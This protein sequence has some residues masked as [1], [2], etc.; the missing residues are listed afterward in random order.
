MSAVC[1]IGASLTLNQMGSTLGTVSCDQ[2]DPPTI[3]IWGVRLVRF[4]LDTCPRT[5]PFSDAQESVT[6]NLFCNDKDTVSRWSDM[7]AFQAGGLSS[8][9]DVGFSCQAAWIRQCMEGAIDTF[10]T[11]PVYLASCKIELTGLRD[12]T[13][14]LEGNT[15]FLE[16]QN[17][18]NELY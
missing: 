13:H 8:L 3:A 5:F 7:I 15:P 11:L 17:I 18:I 16:Y 1:P 9:G 12:T 10:P 6:L 14:V 2:S 4:Q